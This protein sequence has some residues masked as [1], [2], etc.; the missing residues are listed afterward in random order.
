MSNEI[1]V[2]FVS[3]INYPEGTVKVTYP[4]KDD[5]VTA[6]LPVLK[7]G[8]EYCMPEVDDAVLVVHLSNNSASGIVLGTYWTDEEKSDENMP[9]VRKKVWGKE[10]YEE[11]KEGVFL[12]RAPQIV[13]KDANGQITLR[14]L[15][16]M[17]KDIEFLRGGLP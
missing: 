11:F 3:S 10:A 13:L 9:G 7:F 14:E 6:D 4:D 5:A 12:I 1:R 15:L 2:G 16:Q 17:K 8:N